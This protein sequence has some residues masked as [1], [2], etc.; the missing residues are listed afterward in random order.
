MRDIVPKEQ[1]KIPCMWDMILTCTNEGEGGSEGFNFSSVPY[2]SQTIGGRHF[3]KAARHMSHYRC[4]GNRNR[5][6]L[7][8][9]M[10][11]EE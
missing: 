7:I 5:A 9:L 6:M 2:C 11:C 1:E 10:K 4:S 8:E 3:T